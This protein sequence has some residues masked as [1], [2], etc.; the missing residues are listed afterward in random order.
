[1]LLMDAA[2]LFGALLLALAIDALFGDPK[3]PCRSGLTAGAWLW[4]NFGPVGAAIA[5]L[6]FV[7]GI[8][9]EYVGV[10]TG[11]PST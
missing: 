4:L 2:P 1:M 6:V 9:L 11:L 7:L 5:V 10:A 3:C 8:G